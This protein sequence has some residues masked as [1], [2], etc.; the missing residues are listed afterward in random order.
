MGAEASERV[1]IDGVAVELSRLH[2]NSNLSVLLLKEG[3]DWLC[4]PQN[5][6]EVG[7]LAF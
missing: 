1:R 4:Q 6:S 5:M 2:A 7:W 3:A